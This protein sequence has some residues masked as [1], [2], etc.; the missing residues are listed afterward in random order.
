M[1]LEDL[2][3]LHEQVLAELGRKMEDEKVK[4]MERLR[5]LEAAN[6]LAEMSH[7]RRPYPK[8]QPKYQN[9]NNPTE[10]WSGRGKQPRWLRAQIR[11]GKKAADF[12]IE[13]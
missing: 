1:S 9:P 10:T 4:L 7:Q 6:A 12:L 3:S 11:S 5:K 2:W 8:V 13:R